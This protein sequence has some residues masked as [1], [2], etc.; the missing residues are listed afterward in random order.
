MQAEE[1]SRLWI[2]CSLFSAALQ[3]VRNKKNINNWD[4]L[5]SSELFRRCLG[6]LV[7][8]M[9]EIEK[10][11]NCSAGAE[12]ERSSFECDE[13]ETLKT[14]VGWNWGEEAKLN[15][16]AGKWKSDEKRKKKAFEVEIESK[17]IFLLGSLLFRRYWLRRKGPTVT[18]S[19]GFFFQKNNWYRWA[20]QVVQK[21]NV[22]S[23]GILFK[24]SMEKFGF[25]S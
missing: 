1:K 16:K 20:S 24:K 9:A 17:K 15:K 22:R 19:F 7:A 6:P 4:F 2:F 5:F 14:N 11:Q 3:F 12:Y 23:S 10:S 8:E 13:I 18:Q 25:H 21:L